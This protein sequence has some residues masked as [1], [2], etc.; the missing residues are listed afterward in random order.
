MER[1]T[2][3]VVVL[4]LNFSKIVFNFGRQQDIVLA[5]TVDP[6]ELLTVSLLVIAVAVVASLQPAWKASRMEPID[7]LR[8]I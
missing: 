4:I 2:G 5:P 6:W 1:C 8:H 3:V 7:A